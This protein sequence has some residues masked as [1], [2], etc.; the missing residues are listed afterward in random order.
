MVTARPRFATRHRARRTVWAVLLGAALLAVS[1]AQPPSPHVGDDIAPL[2]E[3]LS[4]TGLYTGGSLSTL[5]A[6]VLPFAPQYALWSDG[7]DKHR[8]IWLPSGTSIDASQPDAWQFPR[9]TKLWKEFS[10]AGR[11]IE[12]RTIERLADGSWRYAAYVWNEAGTEAHLAPARGVTVHG[13]A[14]APEGR[15][16]VPARADCTGCHDG[17]AQ[18]V[19]G[20]SALQLSRDRDPLAPPAATTA[21]LTLEGLVARGL[22]NN[23]PSALL[24]RPPRIAAASPTERAALGYLHANCGHCHNGSGNGVPLRLNLA[25][26][27]AD[28]A[29]SRTDTL[30]STLG[31]EGRFR[32]P[33]LPAHAPLVAPAQ[34]ESSVLALR[35]RSRHAQLQMPPIGTRATD[36]AGL[37]LVER[38]IR[39]DTAKP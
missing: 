21:S 26:S 30:R 31:V 9:G 7:A 36:A 8:W 14:T 2:P 39:H 12:T 18:P 37:E 5:R 24:A 20:F 13:V 19:L 11:R 10:Q 35:M 22:L 32:T 15:Y 16:E 27:A 28:A 23:L 4:D 17:A 25:Q 6:G 1:H 33:A 34:P 38:W 3:R 29:R